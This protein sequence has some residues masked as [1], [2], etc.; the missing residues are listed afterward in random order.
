MSRPFQNNNFIAHCYFPPNQL[1]I[2]FAFKCSR[3]A[4][5]I[6]SCSRQ[7]TYLFYPLHPNNDVIKI[8]NNHMVEA[9]EDGT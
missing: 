7:C 5:F 4:A 2:S 3:C 1:Y 8:L 9:W 6:L